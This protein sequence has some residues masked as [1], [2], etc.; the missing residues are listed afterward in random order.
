M[1]IRVLATTALLLAGGATA[2]AASTAA[3][4]SGAFYGGRDLGRAPAGVR[5]QVAVVLKY[6]HQ[7]ELDRSVIEAWYAKSG[8]AHLPP[9][10]T[11]FEFRGYLLLTRAGS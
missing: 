11:T 7:A 8:L 4:D 2:V 3:V 10:P 1:L 5:V 6:H 9:V